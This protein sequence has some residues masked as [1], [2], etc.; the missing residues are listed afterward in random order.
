MAGTIEP[1]EL[2]VKVEIK[3]NYNMDDDLSGLC[4]TRLKLLEAWIDIRHPDEVDPES[5]L[6]YDMEKT[7]VHEL[8]HIHFAPFFEDDPSQK[9]KNLA[10]EQAIEN[11]AR[12]LVKLK[13]GPDIANSIGW[14]GPHCPG[15]SEGINPGKCLARQVMPPTEQ[16]KC[17]PQGWTKPDNCREEKR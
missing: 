10:Q 9:L 1:D 3:R 16:I 15:C 4:T 2:D 5:L 7:L 13:R 6:P 12:A 14:D 17:H 11:I 8:L